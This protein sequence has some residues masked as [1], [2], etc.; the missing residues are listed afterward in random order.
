MSNVI[1]S[2]SP[3]VRAK[4]ST[5]RIMI[6]V[7]IALLPCLV[8]AVIFFGAYSLAIASASIVCAVLTELVYSAIYRKVWKDFKGVMGR[9]FREFDFTSV[10][11]GLILALIIPTTY[12]VKGELFYLPLYLPAIGSVFSIALAKMVF[13][14]TGRNFAN[15]AASGRI[16]LFISFTAM[17]T[18]CVGNCV[19]EP[20]IKSADV[21][22]ILSGA[23]PLTAL[24][25]PEGG[26]TLSPLDL[27]LGT[28]V[29][30][31][32][33]ETCKIAILIGYAYL[34]VRRVIKWYYPLI[35]IGTAGVF[36]VMLAGFNFAYF[37][38]SILS[39]GLLFGAVF[40]ATDYST[41]PKSTLAN[42]IYY[43]CLGLLNSGLRV[44]T[45]IEVTSFCILLMNCLVPL[46]DTYLP[47]RPFGY[48][49]AKKE[50][51]S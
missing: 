19:I 42:V 23:T 1:I 47:R 25:L 46:L 44:A 51:K 13:G 22:E 8:A 35:Y 12:A 17:L 16:V 28:G 29:D 43:V 10:V 11:S 38:P 3:H 36:A 27:L 45:G 6:D 4:T 5:R 15:P 48:V 40:M 33:G 41:S 49:R 50:V 24:Y 20:I 39:G 34:A 14:G 9:L 26:L 31:S 18:S 30:G 32:M 37:L 2:A 7:C 21:S